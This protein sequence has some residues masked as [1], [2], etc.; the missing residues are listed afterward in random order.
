M[1]LTAAM[2]EAYADPDVQTLLYETFEI[3]HPSFATGPLY[4]VCNVEKD[5]VLMN[6]LHRAVG[7]QVQLTGFDD[8]GETQGNIVIDNVSSHLIGPLREAVKAGHPLTVIYRAFTEASLVTPGEVRGGM[9]LS[10]VSLSATSASG[11]LEP[12]SKHD[13]QAFPRK[14]YDPSIFKALH[15]AA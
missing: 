11:T 8:D 3:N 14:T 1:S 15:G 6:V 2:E 10:K 13:T 12:A 5:M 7:V 9:I 4:F